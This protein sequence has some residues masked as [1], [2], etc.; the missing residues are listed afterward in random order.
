M[1][2]E[3]FKEFVKTKPELS[4]YVENNTM[5]WQKFYE[6][7]D[8]YG[9]DEKIWSKYKN[10]QNTSQKLPDFIEKFD[11]DSLKKHIESAQKALDIFNELATKTTENI[12]TNIKPTIK[13]PLTKFFGD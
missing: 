7:Y 4:S 9:E 5:T 3:T 1:S 11:P 6:L 12:A 13:R 10:N 2:K 8:M